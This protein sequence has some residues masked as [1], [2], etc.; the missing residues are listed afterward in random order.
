MLYQVVVVRDRTADVFGVPTFT[1][2]IGV[3]IRSFA[4]EVNRKD[5]N[6][7][8]NRHP[9]DFDLYHIGTYDDSDASMVLHAPRQIAIGK[10]LLRDK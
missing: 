3:A 6:N 5:A 2:A 4:D 10:D 9:D 7:M 1:T 8:F